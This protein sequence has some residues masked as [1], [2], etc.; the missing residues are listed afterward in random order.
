MATGG[1]AVRWRATYDKMGDRPPRVTLLFA[2]RPP[3][4]SRRDGAYNA[5]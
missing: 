3:L 1:E 5:R 4:A 2:L